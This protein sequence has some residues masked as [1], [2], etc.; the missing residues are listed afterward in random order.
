MK[1]NSQNTFGWNADVW[2][3]AFISSEEV[4][5]TLARKNLEVLEIGAGIYSQ[6]AYLFDQTESDITV[7]YYIKENEITL[8]EIVDRKTNEFDLVS[9]YEVQFVDAFNINKKYD[10]IILKSVLGGIFKGDNF[11]RAEEFCQKIVMENLNPNGV[12]I[13]IDNGKSVLEFLLK[14]FGARKNNWRYTTMDELLSADEKKGFGLLSCFSFS[15]RLGSIGFKI[16]KLFYYIDLV[17]FSLFNT[18]PTVIC[19]VFKKNHN[20][21]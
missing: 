17:L 10:V 1:I 9:Q 12:L 4:Q 18:K 13:T 14:N 7:G 19:S 15:T 3:R 5:K 20:P 21:T 16:E 11:A 8:K 6:V 2:Y